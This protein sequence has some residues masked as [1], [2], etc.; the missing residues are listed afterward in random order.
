MVIEFPGIIPVGSIHHHAS[1]EHTYTAAAE[2]S[3]VCFKLLRS[4]LL[5]SL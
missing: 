3:I 5:A 4:E 1:T 2:F